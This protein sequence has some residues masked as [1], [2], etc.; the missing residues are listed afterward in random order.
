[1]SRSQ[2]CPTLACAGP[3][4]VPSETHWGSAEGPLWYFI[5]GEGEDNFDIFGVDNVLGHIVRRAGWVC[6]S[7]NSVVTD[8]SGRGFN[9]Y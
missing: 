5:D 6:T 2:S 1:M 4:E 7:I 8:A 9:L 3:R